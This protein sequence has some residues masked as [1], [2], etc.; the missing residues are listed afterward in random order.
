MT[1]ATL[2]PDRD[3]LEIFADAMMRHR[4]H[5]G[6][7]SLRSFL[8]GNKL[9]KPP[10]TV[11]LKGTSAKSLIDV[12]EDQA[13][14]AANN[15][16]PAVFCAPLCVFDGAEGWRARE[17]DLFKGLA[18]SV[19]CDQHPDEARC[20]L[21]DILGPATAIVR[22]GGQW[23]DPNDGGAQ[24]KL[25]LHWRLKKPAI[26]TEEKDGRAALKQA[27][28]LAA[29]IVGGDI[30]NVPVV[31]CL[32]WPGSWHRKST[33]RLCELISVD[34]DREIDLDSALAELRKHAPPDA[35]DGSTARREL[36]ERALTMLDT[37]V[38]KLFLTAKKTKAAI[39]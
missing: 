31:H 6:C 21:E 12:A 34:P 26:K 28:E 2:K 11:K 24:D 16:M 29:A 37:W 36:N 9:L 17:E 1:N 20:K 30:S 13:R 19:E 5:E 32:R 3:Q 15:P 35:G 14:R 4:G 7:V 10:G 8:H 38:P 18:L 33:A 27:R 25:H 23:I 22:S 39:A